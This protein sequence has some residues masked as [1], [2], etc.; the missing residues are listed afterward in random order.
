[1]NK[2]LSFNFLAV[3]PYSHKVAPPLHGTSPIFTRGWE[4]TSFSTIDQQSFSNYFFNNCC[5][6]CKS[7]ILKYIATLKIHKKTMITLTFPIIPA[8]PA[9]LGGYGT[10][11]CH[12]KWEELKDDGKS[13][14]SPNSFWQQAKGR[15][16][17]AEYKKQE[18]FKR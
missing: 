6:F 1:M 16:P 3:I 15:N 5:Y 9:T 18:W 13:F 7:R 4:K 11:R 14:E 17:K 2:K 12:L 10:L 8:L